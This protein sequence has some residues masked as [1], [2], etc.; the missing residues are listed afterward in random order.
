MNRVSYNQ[1]YYYSH[2]D[3]FKE[4]AIANREKIRL[5]RKEHATEARLMTQKWR[6]AHIEERKIQEKKSKAQKLAFFWSLKQKPCVDCKIQYHPVA[7]D[8]DHLPG[9]EKKSING[10][11][12]M[13]KERLL[14]EIKKCELVCSNCH[15][16]RTYNRVKT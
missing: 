14:E 7:M 2:L 9:Y 8:F 6:K 15:R 3:K 16:L 5:Y 11:A 1:K 4:Y 10:F 12:G 13:S